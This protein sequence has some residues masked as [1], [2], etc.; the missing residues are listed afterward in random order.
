MAA[1]TPH[2]PTG[3]A[4]GTIF[5]YA[6]AAKGRSPSV[7]NTALEIEKPSTKRTASEGQAS[8]GDDLRLKQN[9]ENASLGKATANRSSAPSSPDL[10]TTS[11]STLTKDDDLFSPQNG[12]SESTSDKQSDNS[13]NGVKVAE[14][15]DADKQSNEPS[16]SDDAPPPVA[17]KEAPPPAVNFWH[18][19][20]EAQEAKTRAS[21]QTGSLAVGS[22]ELHPENPGLSKNPTETRKQDNQRKAKGSSHNTESPLAVANTKDANKSLDSRV[23]RGE[24]VST[25]PASRSTKASESQKAN[26]TATVPLDAPGDAMSWPTP[27]NALGEEKRKAQ[28]RAEKAE[29][30]K[31]VASASKPHG[32]PKWVTIPF[33]PTA[34]FNTPIP[35][36]RRGGGRPNR[37]GRDAGN[38]RGGS[39]FQGGNDTEKA[40]ASLQDNS[41]NQAAA[42]S[43]EGGRMD[44]NSFKHGSRPKRSASAGPPTARDQ[45]KAGD[46]SS[47]EKRKEHD[48]KAPKSSIDKFTLSNGNRGVATAVHADR[49]GY[50][51][52]T[53]KSSIADTSQPNGQAYQIPVDSG[54]RRQ[55][56]TSDTQAYAR[57]GGPDRRSEAPRPSDYPRDPFAPV[58]IRER[59]D[60]RLDRGRGGYRSRGNGHQGFPNASYTNGHG[61]ANGHPASNQTPSMQSAKLHSNHD[62]HLSQTQGMSY[63]QSYTHPRS[64]RSNS[65][66][67]SIPHS[68]SY[69]RYSN[70]SYAG[71]SHL[72]N[73]QTDVANAYGYPPG[74]Q[75]VM[76]A[77]PHNPY[78]EQF[79]L[80]GMV[81]MQ[82]CVQ[83][84]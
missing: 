38:G 82:M 22:S 56:M 48:Q 5:S 9:P 37:G 58:P 41:N 42:A 12:F 31:G 74:Q 51:G 79:S 34:K 75:G 25:K 76:S 72:A 67:R 50:G 77:I 39:T 69:G 28:E 18:Q 7:P 64:L 32:Q 84:S 11:T 71:P 14:K 73:I 49:E 20:K 24:E 30:D 80:Y 44:Y 35:Q 45:R 66:S 10:G 36:T 59:G 23:R 16:W 21:K 65:R 17:L 27:D 53:V 1:I 26:P 55:S 57:S 70:A 15:P 4:A 78:S 83:S 68:G 46:L 19:R 43:T 63:S 29:K 40:A 2:K 33:V 3:D 62:R 61:I 60:G 47:T 13:Q 54:E 8:S 6:Q 52:P 81:A